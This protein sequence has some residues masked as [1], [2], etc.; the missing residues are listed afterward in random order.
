[1]A[2]LGT[3]GPRCTPQDAWTCTCAQE[4][5]EADYKQRFPDHAAAFADILQ[6]EDASEDADM[7]M[8][9][10]GAYTGTS[11]AK[12]QEEGV[13]SGAEAGSAAAQALLQGALL[14]DIVAA[15]ARCPSAAYA[16]VLHLCLAALL[17]RAHLAPDRFTTS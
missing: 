14:D 10:A 6:D 12:E 13:A 8:D 15:H 17:L 2:R 5:D 4:V 11:G 3:S 7:G 16:A 1:M 9:A